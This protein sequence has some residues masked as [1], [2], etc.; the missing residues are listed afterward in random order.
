MYLTVEEKNRLDDQLRSMQSAVFTSDHQLRSIQVTSHTLATQSLNTAV[1]VAVQTDQ[2]E[3]NKG[4]VYSEVKALVPG[5]S[6][7]LDECLS[8]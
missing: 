8:D 7:K 4:H 5:A 1:M 2:F 6:N 3:E